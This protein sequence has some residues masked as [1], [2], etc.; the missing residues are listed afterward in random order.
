MDSPP[1]ACCVPV[2]ARKGVERAD[3]ALEANATQAALSPTTAPP[4]EMISIPAG[5]FL[6]GS[7]ESE[8]IVGDGE[9]PQRLVDV[10][11]FAVSATAVSN[12]DF[13]R[14]VAATGWV[15]TAESSG[16]SFVFHGHLSEAQRRLAQPAASV[17]WW[18]AVAGAS[19]RSPRGP[20]SNVLDIVDHPVVHV[21]RRDAMAFCRWSNSRLPTESEW[22]RAARGGRD[23]TRFPWGDELE[24]DGRHW[25]NVFQGHFPASDR[26]DDGFSGTAPVTAYE[27]NDFGLFNVV[28]NVWEWCADAWTSE[29]RGPSIETDAFVVKGGSYLCH[30]SYCTRYRLGA[31][32][33]QPEDST[34]GNLGFRIARSQ[35]LRL[36]DRPT[37][38]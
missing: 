9:T 26:G 19:W 7:S 12:A 21:S 5:R 18:L 38:R 6:M 17:P 27:P 22:E 35:A 24:M 34:A 11:A 23:G 29:A 20:G 13:A 33:G 32:S 8:A 1:A 3:D 36:D 14:F 10:A 31:R 28:G 16:W 30:A 4:V 37:T 25:A 15:T 2:S